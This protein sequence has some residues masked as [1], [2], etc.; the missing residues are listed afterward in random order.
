MIKVSIVLAIG[1]LAESALRR[2]SASARHWILACTLACAALVPALELVAPQWT[3][4]LDVPWLA[5]QA[6][7]SSFA[8]GDTSAG[9]GVALRT[10]EAR[11]AA[12][13]PRGRWRPRSAR[14]GW[15]VPSS[16]WRFSASDWDGWRPSSGAQRRLLKERGAMRWP[17]WPAA[18]CRRLSVCFKAPIPRS[19]SRGACGG[20]RSCS[21]RVRQTGRQSAF[22]P[23]SATNSRT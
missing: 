5:G 20:R 23:S 18:R 17:G 3:L 19:C 9:G 16:V 12:R 21:R 4:P 7:D 13:C 6:G 8:F 1:L 10:G 2:H 15:R 11:P 22:A 14:P